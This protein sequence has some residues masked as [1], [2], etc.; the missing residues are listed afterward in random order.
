MKGMTTLSWNLKTIR[1]EPVLVELAYFSVVLCLQ[2]A[3]RDSIYIIV[4]LLEMYPKEDISD[5]HL[6]RQRN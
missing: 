4:V 5:G 1:C 6:H 2:I 3:T